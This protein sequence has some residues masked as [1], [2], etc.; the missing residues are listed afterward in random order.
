MTQGRSR[1]RAAVVGQDCGPDLQR[2]MLLTGIAAACLSSFVPP[3]AAQPAGD[4]GPE[5]FLNISKFLTGRSSLD[6]GQSARL[7]EALAADLPKFE[8]DIR[9]LLALVVDRRI[10]AAHLQQILDAENSPLAA[11]PRGIV[12]AWYTGIVGEGGAARCITF[13]TSLMYQVVADRLRP[14]S[15]CYGTHGSWTEPPV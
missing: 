9:A 8:A 11:L 14:P 3:G 6:V 15:Y 2:R 12:T 5:T 10:D 7:Y 4:A 13:E 1:A